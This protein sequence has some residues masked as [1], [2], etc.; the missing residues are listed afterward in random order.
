M[1]TIKFIYSGSETRKLTVSGRNS[2]ILSSDTESTQF[3]FKFPDTYK[4]Y[5]KTIIWDCYIPNAEGVVANPRY[6]FFNDSFTIP[7]EI[8]ANNAGKQVSFVISFSNSRTDIVETSLP[9]PV[10]ITRAF[11]NEKAY[12]SSDV[13]SQLTNRAFVKATYG[14]GEDEFTSKQVPCIIFDTL[15]GTSDSKFTLYLD[16]LPYLNEQ[17]KIPSEFISLDDVVTLYS[18]ASKADLE[19]LTEAVSPDMAI[20]TQGDEAGDIYI[21]TQDKEWVPIYSGS[22]LTTL[23][24]DVDAIK[25]DCKSYDKH[26]TDQNNPHNVTKAQIGLGNVDDTSDLDKPISTA[27]QNALDEKAD[28][29]VIEDIEA[30]VEGKADESYVDEQ[31][32]LKADKSELDKK[33]SK[34]YVDTELDKKANKNEVELALDGKVD[35]VEGKELSSNDFTDVLKTKLEGIEENAQVNKLEVIKRNGVELDIVDKEV[36]IDVPTKVIQLEDANDYA[37]LDTIGLKNYYLGTKVDVLIEE[38]KADAKV[39]QDADGITVGKTIL[40]DATAELDGLMTKARV[41]QLEKAT[42]NIDALTS[43]VKTN[44]TDI[45]TLKTTKQDKLTAGDNIKI[46]DDNVI[47]ATTDPLEPATSTKLGGIKVGSKL[48]IAEDG[49]LSVSG[50]EIS[51][52]NKLQATIDTLATKEE[53]EKKQNILT[54]SSG[55]K[56]AN[57]TLS[58]NPTYVSTKLKNGTNISL[59]TN[60]DGI[61]TISATGELSSEWGQISGKIHDQKDLVSDAI[62]TW[63][64]ANTYAKNA[65]VIYGGKVYVSLQDDNT[66]NYPDLSSTYW[67]IITSETKTTVYSETIG[68]GE[69][70]E[71]TVTH[72]LDSKDVFVVLRKV[73]DNSFVDAFV[74]ASSNNEVRFTFTTAPA[75]DSIVATI[76][77]G[78]GGAGESSISGWTGISRTCSESNTWTIDLSGAETPDRKL[79]IQTFDSNGVMVEGYVTQKDDKIITIGFNEAISGTAV[80]I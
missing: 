5:T 27:T 69:S 40:Q 77:L 42:E 31:L 41:I 49:I 61:T 23:E 57:D 60:D 67:E 11:S 28:K 24:T 58:I 76:S 70:T 72:N 26:L 55:L 9:Y 78:M 46:S 18:V 7:Y 65:M 71:I 21:L 4:D 37:K 75:V 33:V 44:K 45:S 29:S 10:Y 56:L 1:Q 53:L 20:I 80:L 17:G 59:T 22:R 38:A 2:V 50:L 3:N 19:T 64:S 68:D 39:T 34:E 15:A 48:A 6:L 73:D 8:T 66:N 16:G 79:I 14:M 74:T 43:Q 63:A 35:K 47:T 13:L 30:K 12:M 62:L 25:V 54:V 52:V 36:D 51:D 32:D